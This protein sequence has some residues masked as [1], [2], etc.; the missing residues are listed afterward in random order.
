[1]MLSNEL[2]HLPEKYREGG[3]VDDYYF[4]LGYNQSYVLVIFCIALLFS[5]VVPI[6]PFFAA[7][8]FYIKYQFDKYNLIFTYHK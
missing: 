2:S 5:V 4:N 8:Y 6:I 7:L 3:F 1:M